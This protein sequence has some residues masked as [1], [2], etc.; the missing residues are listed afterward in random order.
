MTL[1][2]DDQALTAL[3]QRLHQVM[4]V[5]KRRLLRKWHKVQRISS[6]DERTQALA[7]LTQAIVDAEQRYAKRMNANLEIEFDA[8]LPIAAQRQAISD[9]IKQHQ[10]VIVAGETGSGK[11]TQLPK[12]CL[13]L[14][15]GVRGMIGHTQPRRLA[16]RSVANRIAHELHTQ[17]GERVGFRVR[18]TDRVSAASQIKLMTDGMLL[19]EIQRD[20]QLLSY[21]TLII[22]EAHERSLNIDFLLGWLTKLLPKRPDLKLI[23]TSATIDTAR[24]SHH[25]N[26]APILT[27]SGR[28]WPVEVRYRPIVDEDR[29]GDLIQAIIAAVE[30]LTQHGS[31]DILVFL[32]GEREIRDVADALQQCQWPHTEIVQLYARLSSAEQ[33]RIFQPQVGR[34][35]VLATNVAETSLTVPGI[36]YVID[37]GLARISRF[38]YRTR[39]QCLPI[40]AISQ[41]SADQRK[42]RCGRVREGICIRLYTEADYLNR[43]LFTDPEILRTNLA[44]VILQMLALGLGDITD[45]PFIQSPDRRYIQAGFK[46]LME[47]NAIES[48]GAGRY[49]LNAIGRQLARFP[50]DPRLAR[51][52]IAAQAF[53]CVRETMIITAALSIQDPREW[54]IEKLQAAQQK[55]QRFADKTSD[56]VTLIT[57]WDYLQQQKKQLST[58]QFRRQCR[59]DFLNHARV[60][61]WQ[62]IY[63]QLRLNARE[64]GLPLQQAPANMQQLH[65]ALLSGLLSHIGHKA[66]QSSEYMGAQGIRFALFPAS[67]LFKKSPPWVM[68]AELVETQRRWGRIAAKIEPTWVEP[69]ALHLTKHSYSEPHWEKQQGAV[70]ALEKVTLFGLPIIAGRKVH[71]ARI[72]AALCREL[73]IRHALL[74]GEWETQHAFVKHNQQVREQIEDLEHKSRRRDILVDEQVLFDFYDQRIPQEIVSVKHFDDWWQ[75][76]ERSDPKRL[77]FSEALLTNPAAQQVTVE[78][79]PA[80]WHQGKIKLRLHYQFEPGHEDDGVTVAI[81]LPLLPQLDADNFVWQ[82]PGLRH[83]L[84]VALIKSLP[85]TLRRHLVPATAFATAFLESATPFSAPLLSAMT[86]KFRRMTG[87]TIPPAAW[88]WQKVP[89]HLTFTFTIIDAQQQ[90]IAKGKVLAQLAQMLK[91]ELQQALSNTEAASIEQRGLTA[92]HFDTLPQHDVLQRDGYDIEV[93]PA[94]VDEKTSVAIRLLDNPTEQQRAMWH[95]VRRL[96]LLTLPSPRKYLQQKLPTLTKLGLCYAPFGTVSQLLE[97]CICCAV[98]KLMALHGGVVWTSAAFQQLSQAVASQLKDTALAIVQ[99]TERLLAPMPM[100]N[101]QLKSRVALTQALALADIKQQLSRLVYPSFVSQS[102]WQRLDDIQRYLLAITYRLEKLARDPV[103]DRAKMLKIHAVEQAIAQKTGVLPA[104]RREEEALQA[105]RWMV[106]E[107]RVSY[108]A[109]QLGTRVPVSDKRILHALTQLTTAPPR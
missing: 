19:A 45:F 44:S 49:R 78:A 76:I 58:N 37:S 7:A 67:G 43:P 24:F 8:A 60:Q 33:N 51:M 96:L 73:F 36:T 57:L 69:L 50:I 93:W 2:L 104:E 27:V 72:D 25:F 102:G 42:G 59:S 11:T 82:V 65:S 98:D 94:L 83:A 84:V 74:N 54:P 68:V 85:K 53:A 99:Q 77:N 5:D 97:D 23:I 47:L 1:P 71:Y 86:A 15:R 90:C 46:L 4:L 26:Q 109:Q 35:I 9:A 88:Q 81:P 14:G 80:Y 20:P 103:A 100:L 92:W 89:P 30:E 105:L 16:A 87:V 107:L 21:D 55:H 18:F 101:K 12:L 106:E 52:I 64:M 75:Q 70:V 79:Y 6:V 61:E 28:T 22:D 41:A 31:G 66:H 10:V 38:N 40:E 39:V 48:L 108:F 13:A 29:G 32:A 91:G 17:V 63:S 95:G 3:R 34:R 56:F 62:D